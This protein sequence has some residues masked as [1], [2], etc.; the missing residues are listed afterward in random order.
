[1]NIFS[2]IKYL[3]NGVDIDSLNKKIADLESSLR[4]VKDENVKKICEITRLE[5]KTETLSMELVREQNEVSMV[6]NKLK[7]TQEE[8]KNKENRISILNEE[9]VQ[10]QE[11]FSKVQEESS[12][13]LKKIEELQIIINRSETINT[14]NIAEIGELKTENERLKI[15]L[16]RKC[17]EVEQANATLG[18]L[19]ISTKGNESTIENLRAQLDVESKTKDSLMATINALQSKNDILQS[20]AD[21]LQTSYDN[22]R[23]EYENLKNDNRQPFGGEIEVQISQTP[24]KDNSNESN[25]SFTDINGNKDVDCD[26][27]VDIVNVRGIDKEKNTLQQ[28]EKNG[29]SL[30]LTQNGSDSIS[31]INPTFPDEASIGCDVNDVLITGDDASDLKNMEQSSDVALK[32]SNKH[33]ETLIED[34]IEAETETKDENNNGTTVE[35]DGKSDVSADD[36]FED[37]DDVLDDDS[38]PYIYDYGLIP[39]GKLSI[40]EVYDVK[41]GKSIKAREFFSQNE[42]ELILWRRNLQEEYLTGRARFICPEC[43][44]PVKISGHKLARGRVCYFAHFKDSDDCPYKTGTN[45]TKEEIE[46]QKYSLVQ[47]SERHKRLK[48]AIASALEGE[49]SRSMGV[50]NVECEKRINSDIPYLNWRRPDIYAEYNGRRYVF[51]LQLSTTFVSVIVDRDIFYRLNDYNIIWI[52]NFEDNQ[53]YVNLHNLMC[54]DIYYANKRNIFIFD[55]DAEEKSKEKGELV[56]KCR[57]LDENGVWSNDKYVTLEMFLYDE[58]THK[59]FIVDADKA[60]LEKF[61]EYVERRKQLEHSREY[62]LMALLERQREEEERERKKAEERSNL[63]QKLLNDGKTVERFRS[64]TK[65]GYQYE[66]T[67]ILPA[68]YTSAE[69][70]R[71][72][73]YAQVGFNRKIGLVR[74]DGKEV[75]PVEYKNINLINRHGVIMAI[76]KRVDL[77]LGDERFVLCDKYN[78]KEEDIIKEEKDGMTK[79][80]LQIKTYDY[81]YTSSY[82]GNHPICHKNGRGIQKLHFSLS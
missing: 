10:L 26:S 11:A 77:W 70:I 15:E 58:E 1:M 63:Q 19:T 41:E 47:E 42:N 71:E 7:E 44:Q 48:A 52:F 72:D 12:V 39:A 17:E 9:K 3:L 67:T 33:P 5:Q 64:G 76:Y 73:G 62:L 68:K 65:F 38:L 53:E 51:E 25:K 35:K 45:R 46:R 32:P 13:L 8:I 27:N 56:L 21:S 74:K 60:Y 14:R 24:I 66:G 80:I 50:V 82:Y 16:E 49:M 28:D 79:Y 20:Q 22:L 30:E 78:D 34:S 57:W 61:P 29:C 40:P 2:N 43:K 75:V 4:K 23:S 54:K 69:D 55:N 36:A 18:E 37:D 59:P 31:K 6:E 81:T